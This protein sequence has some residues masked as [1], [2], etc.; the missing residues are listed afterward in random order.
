MEINEGKKM[1]ICNFFGFLIGSQMTTMMI[2]ISM[3]T[4]NA[5]KFCQ[6][7]SLNSI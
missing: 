5:D 7:W 2:N 6:I 3:G 1:K 4:V